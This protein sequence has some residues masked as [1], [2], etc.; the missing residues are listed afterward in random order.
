MNPAAAILVQMAR[1][2]G[3]AVIDEWD[4]FLLARQLFLE[5]GYRGTP[6]PPRAQ[7]AVRSSLG[8]GL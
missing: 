7:I 1:D 2:T 6:I 4:L 3:R 8:P 5:R